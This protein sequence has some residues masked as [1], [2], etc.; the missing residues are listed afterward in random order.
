MKQTFIF[1]TNNKHKLEEV[2]Q[3]LGDK[4]TLLSLKD[5]N[6]SEDIPENEPT[7]EGN[8]LYKARY[9]YTKFRQDCFADDT[10]LEVEALNGEPGVFSA[11]Y[12][13]EDK[14]YES[15]NQLLL[16]NLQHTSNKKARFKTIIACILDGKEYLFEGIIEGI[17][18]DKPRGNNG[19]GY[20]P[21]FQPIGYA[22]TFGELS[23]DIK[24]TIS[25][26]AKAVEAFFNYLQQQQIV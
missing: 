23:D 5:I 26:R 6:F 16:K 2:Q 14:N 1:A 9:I 10:G 4:V 17:I 8:A 22:N 11:R 25:H 20:D 3:I 24:N 13:G 18:V 12:A 7:I 15:N 21:I 19:F